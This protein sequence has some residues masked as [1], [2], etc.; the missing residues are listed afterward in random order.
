MLGPVLHYT[1]GMGLQIPFS[2]REKQVIELLMQGKSN[3]QI[4]L[5]L[6]VSLRTVEFHLSNVYTK[7]GVT[8]RT[9]A[10]LKLSETYLREST[11]EKLRESTVLESDESSDNV[12]APISTWR[13]PVSRS[14]L[15]GLGILILTSIFCYASLY[16]M[17]KERAEAHD[18]ELAAPSPT[19]M[20]GPAS[21][22][23]DEALPASSRSGLPVQGEIRDHMALVLENVAIFVDRTVL[24]VSLG[25]DQPGITLAAPWNVI[26]TDKDGR[27]YPLTDITPETADIG[28]TRVYQ[29][30]PLQGN[31]NLVLSLV[32]FP[33]HQDL[34]LLMDF[35][36][37]PAGFTFDPGT[38]SQVGQT[39]V[40][41]ETLQLGEFT[42][43]L[44]GARMASPT[45]LIFEFEPIQGVTGA[46]LYSTS[47]SG[48]SGGLPNP[49][50][51]FTAGITFDKV[52][53]LPFEIQVRGIYYTASGPWQVEW[54]ATDAS[55]LNAPVMTP[56]VTPTPLID[57]TLTSQDPLL[58]GVQALS[59]KFDGSI[60]QGPAW[61]HVV[62][63]ILT[64]HTAVGQNYPPP[65]YQDEQWYK[66][67][68]EGWVTRNVT[69]HRDADGNVIQQSASIGTKGINFTSG[70]VFENP[71]YR[72]S[73]DLLTPD[74]DSALGR[75]QPVFREET[76][77]D[78]GSSCL[79]VTVMD[80]FAQ[81]IQ[82]PGE[83]TAFYGHGLRVWMNY[84]TGQQVKY[85]RFWTL[86]D[87][88]EH[89]DYTQRPVL[90]ERVLTPPEG[91]L[92]IL[93]N[94]VM[95]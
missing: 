29:T 5:A 74:L 65:Y 95:R 81:P 90:V 55:A 77:C 78:D 32:S 93:D 2:E 58:L 67:D 34:P 23:P 31:E 19:S 87:G 51:N 30:A 35:S 61:I 18:A 26:M 33:S 48:A 75:D 72:L 91:I 46:M 73:F 9:E 43:H 38:N 10:A 76:T 88:T 8:S 84:E 62:N 47:A 42:L 82:N 80:E 17:V 41:D 66:I 15:I 94:I 79:L 45:E 3:K 12:E 40:V 86:E 69:R 60:V 68:A 49:D 50:G 64:E 83:P 39:W 11:G 28:E 53:N 89:V 85:Q 57:P 63:E 27:I 14:F 54:R 6:G 70:D 92:K 22:T 7:L 24:Q 36:E 1:W 20:P 25:F 37:N 56:A 52:P 13:L 21:L 4:A 59:Q 16:I 71:S 44:V